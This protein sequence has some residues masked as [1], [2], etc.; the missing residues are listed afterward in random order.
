MYETDLLKNRKPCP[1]RDISRLGHLGFIPEFSNALY[2][3]VPL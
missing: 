3:D 2:K 1:R